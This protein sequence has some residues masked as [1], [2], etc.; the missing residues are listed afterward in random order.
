MKRGPSQLDGIVYA[1]ARWCESERAVSG[2]GAFVL[3]LAASALVSI[4]LRLPDLQSPDVTSAARRVWANPSAILLIQWS[5]F[6]LIAR[7]RDLPWFAP[8]AVVMLAVALA[9]HTDPFRYWWIG[10][11]SGVFQAFIHHAGRA[12]RASLHQ[13]WIARADARRGGGADR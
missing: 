4:H 12:A 3:V 6:L 7:R 5:S 10:V 9:W 8:I 11:L 1:I 13:E 2:I